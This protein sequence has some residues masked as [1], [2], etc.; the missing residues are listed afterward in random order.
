MCHKWFDVWLQSVLECDDMFTKYFGFLNFVCFLGLLP[1]F[2]YISF[3]RCHQCLSL[4]PNCPTW[5]GSH[6]SYSIPIVSWLIWSQFFDRP[7]CPKYQ[8]FSTTD[9]YIGIHMRLRKYHLFFCTNKIDEVMVRRVKVWSRCPGFVMWLGAGCSSAQPSPQ[10]SDHFTPIQFI[11]FPGLPWPTRWFIL[12]GYHL[13]CWNRTIS[14]MPISHHWA[15]P[16]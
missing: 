14:V 7:C 9:F 10:Y 13:Y 16:K 1:I 12:Q 15:I 2:I 8:E 4:W 6:A 5:S 11:S 3:I